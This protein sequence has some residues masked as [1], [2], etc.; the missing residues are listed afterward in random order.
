MGNK[1]VVNAEA[2]ATEEEEAF[3]KKA[4]AYNEQTAEQIEQQRR[5]HEAEV[6]ARE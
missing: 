3:A 2:G 6:E 4:A 5:N 1:P